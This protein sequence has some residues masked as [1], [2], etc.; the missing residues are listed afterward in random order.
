MIGNGFSSRVKIIKKVKNLFPT[1]EICYGFTMFQRFK[2]LTIS[3]A[4]HGILFAV[5]GGSFVFSQKNS[6]SVYGQESL[7]ASRARGLNFKMISLERS[8]LKELRKAN[9]KTTVNKP[10]TDKLAKNSSKKLIPT[11]SEEALAFSSTQATEQLGNR[12]LKYKYVEKIRKLITENYQYPQRAL[13]LGQEG[14][15]VVRFEIK[16]P[17]IINKLELSQKS[18]FEILDQ[19]AL[20]AVKELEE[21]PEIPA[22][23]EAESLII[24]VPIRFE[25]L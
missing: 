25:N 12:D 16:K 11:P 6:V 17:N 18:P 14:V 3:C 19:A 2:F 22:E 8:D 5:L 10:K 20:K 15:A 7:K 1:Q 13:K 24:S 4:L 23:V 21:I 9:A